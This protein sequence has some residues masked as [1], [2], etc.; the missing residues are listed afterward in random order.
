MY[1]IFHAKKVSSPDTCAIPDPISSIQS[2]TATVTA[3]G[4]A[5][6]DKMS[7]IGTHTDADA[8][9]GSKDDLARGLKRVTAPALIIG[10]QSDLLFP[11]TQQREIAQILRKNGNKIVRYYE[12][13]A[14]YGHDTFLID[15]DTVGTVCKPKTKRKNNLR[16][17]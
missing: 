16:F 12:L 6:I 4:S 2:A 9:M 8:A 1:L 7:P 5:L 13:D 17:Q 11:V 3:A 14:L 15:V 10:V